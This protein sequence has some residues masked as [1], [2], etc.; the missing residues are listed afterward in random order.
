MYNSAQASRLTSGFNGSNSSA[1]NELVSSLQ[2]LRTR[3]RQLVRDTA[4]AK[5]A[6]VIVVNNVIGHG[7]GMQAEVK[8]SRDAFAESVNDSIEKAWEEWSCGEDCHTGGTLHFAD[9]ERA[10][11]GQIF[12][13]GE[14]FIRIH[15]RAFGDSKIPFALELIEAERL[16]DDYSQPGPVAP[17]AQVRMGVEVDGFF[18]PLAYW[19]RNAHPSEIRFTGDS[20]IKMERVDAEDIFHLRIVDRWPQTRGE[21]WMHS[22]IR[23]LNDIDGYTEAEIIAARS[24]ASY[25]GFI[26]SDNTDD[27]NNEV[28]EDGSLQT[29]LSPGIID[30]LRPGEKFNFAAPNRP[31]ANAEAFL[32]FMLREMA[33][34]TGVS[35]E[36]LSRDYSQSNYSSSR[37]ALLDDRDL[38]KTFQLW[39]MRAFR[40]ELHSEWLQAAVLSGAVNIPIAQ[41][42]QDA[43]KFEAV[44]FK[45]RGWSWVDPTK[46]VEA[47]KEAV[48]A[49]FITVADVIAQTG[50]GTDLEDVIEG[51]RRE[52][53]MMDQADLE[54]DTS[55]EV[56]N[57][58]AAKDQALAKA[59]LKPAE[60]APVPDATATPARSR[61]LSV[62]N[63]PRGVNHE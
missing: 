18:R 1:D 57:S 19:I 24:A 23:K 3:S 55:P 62:L 13:A 61:T 2:L 39:W 49:G 7:M 20:S 59:A 31:N 28:Q 4:F 22:V 50:N 38:W 8:T 11:F 60:P 10:C 21:P 17:G 45:A 46:E 15:R 30:R 41:Y 54:F 5:R 25:M 37:L 53:D 29:E 32:R 36:S 27:P 56:Y 47:Y 12:E 42:A 58:A 26:E 51:R 48:K 6:R 9:F 14:V 52:L 63:R 44:S 35:Y 40:K 16:A 34:G 33:A 43:G